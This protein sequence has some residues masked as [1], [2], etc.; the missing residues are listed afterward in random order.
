MEWEYD[1]CGCGRGRDGFHTFS[2]PP[3]RFVRRRI[4]LGIC[5]LLLLL[6]L[7]GR[8]EA[9]QGKATSLLLDGGCRLDRGDKRG[10]IG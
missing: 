4:G 5:V 1:R 3:T 2:M 7:L 6:L 8:Q 10:S 9:R